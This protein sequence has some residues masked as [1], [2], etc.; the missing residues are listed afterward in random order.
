MSRR[1]RF[2]VP[3]FAVVSILFALGYVGSSCCK[4]QTLQKLRSEFGEGHLPYAP[5][6]PDTRSGLLNKQTGHSGLFYNCDGE[7]CKRFSPHICWKSA[8]SS[9]LHLACKDIFN[10]CRDRS[11]IAQRICDGAGGCC[12]SGS[13]DGCQQGCCRSQGTTKRPGHGCSDCLAMREHPQ[14]QNVSGC[15]GLIRDEAVSQSP[16]RVEDV[17]SSLPLETTK[18]EPKPVRTSSLLDRAH[19]LRVKR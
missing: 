9:R 7:E 13:C 5:R 3:L 14:Q 6:D 12:K 15:V 18:A 1:K 4:A 8:E 16:A 17:V 19:S 2:R 11:E 10:W